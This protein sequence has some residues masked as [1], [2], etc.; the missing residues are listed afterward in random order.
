MNKKQV[1]LSGLLALAA[2]LLAS[3]ACNLPG[4]N[5]EGSNGADQALLE[6]ASA[7]EPSNQNSPQ[8]GERVTITI[9]EGQLNAIVQ[10]AIENDPTQTVNGLQL[11]LQSGE[12]ALSGTVVQEGLRLPLQ[13]I[14]AISPDG[15]GGLNYQVSSANVGPLP[16]PQSMRSQIENM[17]NQGLDD[18]VRQMT[19]NI[20]IEEITIGDGV[21][22]VVGRTQ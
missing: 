22:N 3:L 21:L 19:N 2:L 13:I 17:L 18:P 5:S 14:L 12:V 11:R 4:L 20:F 7:L 10:Q 8:A 9:T 16:L 6:T 15:Q 1:R